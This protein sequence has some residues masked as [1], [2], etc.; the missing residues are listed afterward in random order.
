MSKSK[1]T[2]G[3]S[4]GRQEQGA[5]ALF[6]NYE[7]LTSFGQGNIEAVIEANQVLAKGFEALG[8]EVMGFAQAQLEQATLAARALFGARTLQD[9]IAVNNDFAR[10]SF[11][12]FL[13]NSSKIGELGAKV[14]NDAMR[15]LGARVNLALETLGKPAAA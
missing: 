5:T 11:E 13:E 6:E 1:K 4:A 10:S 8:K 14:A 3:Q 7:Q 9:V 15:P 12:S 2:A